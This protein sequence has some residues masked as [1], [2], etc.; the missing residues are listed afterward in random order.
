MKAVIWILRLVA[1]PDGMSRLEILVG[2]NRKERTEAAI[3]AISPYKMHHRIA[4]MAFE[5]HGRLVGEL[6]DGVGRDKG[7]PSVKLS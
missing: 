6:T 1:G 3:A 4:L 7:N 5:Q 2:V